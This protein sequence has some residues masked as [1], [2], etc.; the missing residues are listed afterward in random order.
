MGDRSLSCSL[1]RVF[2]RAYSVVL[3]EIFLALGCVVGSTEK[4][5]CHN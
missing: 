4:I 3:S 2:F 1:V 5:N